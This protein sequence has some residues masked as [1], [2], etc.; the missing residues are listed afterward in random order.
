MLR[1]CLLCYLFII[2]KYSTTQAKVS[3]W[4]THKK[5]LK[6]TSL[7]TVRYTT[8]C[9]EHM[10]YFPSCS[11]LYKYLLEA[12]ISK[13][14]FG[15]C[16]G[17]LVR[18]SSLLHLQKMNGI[19]T[20]RRLSSPW[21]RRQQGPPKRWYATTTLQDVTIQK[22]TTWIFTA[23]KTSNFARFAFVLVVCITVDRFL[24]CL[25]FLTEIHI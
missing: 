12:L 8:L 4:L 19:R 17:E 11:L 25:K 9:T 15:T 16:S 20:V 23:M 5:N 14:T 3:R 18:E 7:I 10:K 2:K 22:I 1:T 13:I 6:E 24:S 21:R